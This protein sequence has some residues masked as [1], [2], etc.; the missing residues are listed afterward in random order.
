M[1]KDLH[2]GTCQF[3]Y[4]SLSNGVFIP[5][6]GN[7]F[8]TLQWHI[9]NNSCCQVLTAL[10]QLSYNIHWF[11]TLQWHISMLAIDFKII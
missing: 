5:Q 7:V 6:K 1:F 9:S 2:N 3:P 11:W 10:I 4:M 8:R